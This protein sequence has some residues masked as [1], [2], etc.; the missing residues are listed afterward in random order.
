MFRILSNK[1][2]YH[3][4]LNI[5]ANQRSCLEY[6]PIRTINIISLNILATQRACLEYDPISIIYMNHMDQS[7]VCLDYDPIRTKQDK[8][9]S[10]QKE[11]KTTKLIR[12]IQSKIS[13]F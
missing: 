11:K 3:Y 1:D 7:W 8:F 6:D 4:S 10:N 2:C 13:L 12:L 5:L 9:F